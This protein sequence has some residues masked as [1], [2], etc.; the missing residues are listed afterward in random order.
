MYINL[1]EILEQ[2][3]LLA[4]HL[5]GNSGAEVEFLDAEI[6][7]FNYFIMETLPLLV[8]IFNTPDWRAR[9]RPDN[10]LWLTTISPWVVKGF[11]WLGWWQ[12]LLWGAH[13]SCHPKVAAKAK[14]GGILFVLARASAA[15]IYFDLI[16][17][18]LTIWPGVKLVLQSC[19]G[20]GMSSGFTRLHMMIGKRILISA[21]IHAVSH[22]V[23]FSVD[24][25]ADGESVYSGKVWDGKVLLTGSTLPHGHGDVGSF[26]ACLPSPCMLQEAQLRHLPI[27][28]GSIHRASAIVVLSLGIVHSLTG[29]LGAPKLFEFCLVLGSMWLLDSCLTDCEHLTASFDCFGGERQAGQPQ[30][31]EPRR[32]QADAQTMV[33]VLDLS[34][35]RQRYMGYVQIRVPGLPGWHPFTVVVH[36]DGRQEL[37]INLKPRTEGSYVNWAWKVEREVAWRNSHDRDMEER[38]MEVHVAGPFPTVLGNRDL[39]MSFER[40]VFISGGTG[41]TGCQQGLFAMSRTVN[42]DLGNRVAFFWRGKQNISYHAEK[43]APCCR[44]FGVTSENLSGCSRDQFWQTVSDRVEQFNRAVGNDDKVLVCVCGDASFLA[45]ARKRFEDRNRVAGDHFD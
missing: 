36:R 41:F 9:H 43:I 30:A 16:V 20:M 44:E 7:V 26:R 12:F 23:W 25:F 29:V 22:L 42:Q 35:A 45:E 33:L 37:H 1:T 39:Y 32:P 10:G 31:P 28:G 27:L 34:G 19:I 8:V 14:D 38:R 6:S 2:L 13:M 17:L 15:S 40:V 5:F 4:R 3:V 24:G 21:S 18:F 11:L